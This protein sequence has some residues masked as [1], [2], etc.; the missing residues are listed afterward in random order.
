VRGVAP[1]GS[2]ARRLLPATWVPL[3]AIAV[4]QLRFFLAYGPSGG[5]E[6]AESG[7][8]YL[9]SV[10]PWIVLL[11]ALGVGGFL[12]RLSL[13][14]RDGEADGAPPHSL[15]RLWLIASAALVLI[16]AGQETLEGLLANGHAAGFGGIFGDGGLWA[17]PSAAAVGG[18]LALL[19]RGGRAAIGL[20]A[21][22]SRRRPSRAR[23]SRPAARRPAPVFIAHAS[24][25]AC[26]APGRAPPVRV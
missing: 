16:Y 2:R 1:I 4:H 18:V 3:S 9:H 15:V 25:L 10:T 24:P 17:L 26:C 21:R 22:L 5:R 7:H 11:C 14:W 6:L 12:R 13:A 8:S 20:A 23:R 19:V